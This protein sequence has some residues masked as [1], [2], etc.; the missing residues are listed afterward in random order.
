MTKDTKVGVSK[1]SVVIAGTFATGIAL[2]ILA[3]VAFQNIIPQNERPPLDIAQAES[4][5]TGT[6]S[7]IGLSSLNPGGDGQIEEI[8]K[9]K[10]V[11]DQ[12]RAL[13]ATLSPATEHELIDWWIQSKKIERASHREIAQQVILRYLTAINP[14]QAIQYLDDV[15]VFE[16]DSLLM[17]VFSEW[18]VSNLDSAIEAAVD[19]IS[20]QR[21]IALQAILEIRD[22]LS[23]SQRRSIALQLDGE[24]TYLKLI[25]DKQ[26]AQSIAEPEDSWNILLNDNVYDRQQLQALAVVVEAW[27]DQAGF[28]V[29]SNIYSDAEDFRIKANMT[30]IIAQIDPNGALDYTRGLE[31][32]EQKWF[33]SYEIVREW[34]RTDALAALAA[35]TT[36]EPPSVASELETAIS[37]RWAGSRPFEAIENIEAVSVNARVVTLQIAFANIARTDPSE[38]IAMLSSVEN[39][40]GNTSTILASIVSEWSSQQPSVATDWVIDNFVR[41]DPQRRMLLEEAL[42]T[43]A[44]EDPNKAFELALAQPESEGTALG[45]DFLVFRTIARQGDLEL[46]KTL[47]PQIRENSEIYAYSELAEVLVETGKTDEAFKLGKG[48]E[49]ELRQFFYQRVVQDWTWE[50]PK[51]LFESLEELPSKELKSKAAERLIANNEWKPLLTDEEIEHAKTFL[52]AEDKGRKSPFE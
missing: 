45:L 26:A 13:H 27:F 35:A 9:H 28:E 29:L 40:V 48:L 18:G 19:L 2:G 41:E 52:I 44:L 37:Y 12:Y 11:F 7:D 16:R 3:V 49:E 39:S 46:T 47:L 14:Q 21:T 51:N 50:D 36:F 4:N 33:L 10:S 15:T 31:D 23:D 17:T 42:P 25:G 5:E 20:P 8:F 43:L 34:A 32:A 1:R 30:R 6:K 24:E 22:D 38:A